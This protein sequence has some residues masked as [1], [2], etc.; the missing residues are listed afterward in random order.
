M[1]LFMKIVSLDLGD[2]WTGTALSDPM[3]ILCKPYQTVK[4]KELD[5]FLK[6]LF[7]EQFIGTV[8]VGLPKTLRNTDSE[9]TK[10]IIS[11]KDYLEKKFSEKKWVLWDER[12]TSKQAQTIKSKKDDKH[13]I[14]SI[15]AA[16]ILESYLLHLQIQKDQSIND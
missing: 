15:A 1:S 3:G 7:Q 11:H 13:K 9:Q 10:K 12:L 5:Q 4:T 2:V 6:T 16:L 8:V 14:H